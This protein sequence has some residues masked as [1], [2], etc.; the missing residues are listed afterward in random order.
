MSTNS[1]HYDVA[2]VGS[3]F[4]GSTTACRLAE[5]GANTVLIERGG[6]AHRDDDDWDAKSI[7][8]DKRYKSDSPVD[9]NLYGEERGLDYP[10]ETVGGMSVFYGGASLRLRE[11]DLERWP[12][13]YQDL[14]PFYEEA[15]AL[16]GVHGQAGAD[17]LEPVREKPYP[18][19]PI[20]LSA[21]AGR[22]H[23]AAESLGHKPFHIPLAINFSDDN[24]PKCILC[25]TCDG[26]PCRIEAKNDL[27]TTVLSRAQAAGL[28]I[29]ANS[30]VTRFERAG[31]RVK[32]LSA[33]DKT[34]GQ[35]VTITADRFVLAA[36]AIHSPAILLRSGFSA[37]YIGKCLMRHYNVIIAC[38]FPFQTNPD[39]TFHKQT[40]LTDFYEKLR[41]ETGTAVG[42][43][44]DIYTPDLAVMK[45]HAPSWAKWVMSL[46]H[47]YMQNLLCVAEDDPRKENGVILTGKKDSYG[48]E[49]AKV[50]H[51]YTEADK[52]RSNILAVAAKDILQEA[53]GR[54]PYR[55]RIDTFSH[56]VGSLR[57]GSGEA[58][59]A[60]DVN[61]RLHGSEN[62]YVSDGSFMPTSGG[63]N[64]SLTIAA[65]GLRVSDHLVRESGS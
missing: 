41:E 62:L 54:F 28:K 43:I 6:W 49:V 44:Q 17:P 19:G 5:A 48:L 16:L 35:P 63:V 2:I 58:D 22:I 37:P 26:Y 57:M 15:E 34:S 56:G 53:G 55:Y 39:H 40:C 42:V 8:L 10:N 11:S 23:E 46:T 20:P 12:I 29:L 9:I 65:N 59:S 27:T 32:S 18:F 61:C 21:P 47:R 38:V 13:S 45:A 1:S 25:T 51:D 52:R 64:P 24:R 60:L 4:G 7:L 3:G 36:G 33:I 50:T 31:S 14:A 30:V